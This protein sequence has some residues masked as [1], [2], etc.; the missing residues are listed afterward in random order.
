MRKWYDEKFFL[1]SKG[2]KLSAKR[3]ILRLKKYQYESVLDV[4]CGEGHLVEMLKA[5]GIRAKGVDYSFYAGKRIPDD[6]VMTDAK[7]LPFKDNRFDVVIS[8][9]FFEHI[10]EKDIDEVYK[11]MQRVSSKYVLAMIS[12]KKHTRREIDTHV[13][14]KPAEWWRDRLPGIILLNVK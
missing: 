8:S 6:F 9:D 3:N 12:F 11:E 7:Y 14:V 2:A 13:T 10:Y 5:R 1:D 4:G